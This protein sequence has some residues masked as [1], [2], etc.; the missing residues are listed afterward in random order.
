[1]LGIFSLDFVKILLDEMLDIKIEGSRTTKE[2]E[3]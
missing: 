2:K 1:M 3:K